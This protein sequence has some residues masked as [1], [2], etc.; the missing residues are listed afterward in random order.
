MSERYEQSLA[1]RILTLLMSWRLTFEQIDRMLCL[2]EGTA[3]S[4]VRE[5]KVP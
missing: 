1:C 4:V 3:E 5:R 2:A